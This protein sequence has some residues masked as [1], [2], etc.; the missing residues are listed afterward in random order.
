MICII[1]D[2]ALDAARFV[3]TR[4]TRGRA[5]DESEAVA[6]FQR[7]RSEL[8]THFEQ[9]DRLYYSTIGGLRP[10]HR[11]AIEGFARAHA[12]LRSRFGEIAQTLESG[13][14]AAASSLFEDFAEAFAHHE[15][16]EESLLRLLDQ[17]LQARG[18]L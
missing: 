12:Q 3:R 17:E 13:S 14:L 10:D 6:A 8:E 5:G 11:E 7:L 1:L 18:A 2:P 15:T 16:G 4:T 9:E